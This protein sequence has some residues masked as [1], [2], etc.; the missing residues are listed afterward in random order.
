MFGIW[1]RFRIGAQCKLNTYWNWLLIVFWYW[2]SL[3]YTMH[4]NIHVS[5]PKVSCCLSKHKPN[6]TC[7]H[8]PWVCFV[9][10]PVTIQS[11]IILRN[12]GNKNMN[13]KETVLCL[14]TDTSHSQTCHDEENLFSFLS[15]WS[16][17]HVNSEQYMNVCFRVSLWHDGSNLFE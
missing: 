4:Q 9:I 7:V 11:F 15:F 5:C 3:H 8:M 1:N 13:S 14:H 2:L 10:L 12:C 17:L 6:E 16:D